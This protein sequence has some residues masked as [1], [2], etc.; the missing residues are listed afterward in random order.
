MRII[1]KR[2]SRGTAALRAKGWRLTAPRRLILDVVCASDAHPTAAFVYRRVRRRLPR[3]SL[4]TVYRNLRRLA[5]EGFLLER[6]D[7]GGMRFDGNLARHDHFTCLC[8][9]RIY[10]VPARRAAGGHMPAGAGF[11]VAGHGT[12]EE[13]W[14]DVA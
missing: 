6:A 9:G 3:V 14:Q 4:A 8:C 7:A 1:P 13:S 12:K 10:D 5:S 2:D 11:E